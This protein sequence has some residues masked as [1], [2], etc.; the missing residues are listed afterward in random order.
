MAMDTPPTLTL[1][2]T[3]VLLGVG[4]STMY[5]A[6]RRAALPFPALK[7]GGRYVVPTRP[8]LD[9]LGI[10]ELPPLDAP[11]DADEDQDQDANHNP[12]AA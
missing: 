10:E 3:A 1:T 9:L 12:E 6:A 8:L 11:S 7:V 5:S 4:V 2:E